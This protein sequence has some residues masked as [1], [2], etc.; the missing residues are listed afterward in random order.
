MIN[1]SESSYDD[2]SVDASGLNGSPSAKDWTDKVGDIEKISGLDFFVGENGTDNNQ[3]CT[4]KNV[5]ALGN[6]RGACPGAPRLSGSY[7]LTGLAHWAHTHD[8]RPLKGDQKVTT[9]AVALL[10]GVPELV[11][12]VPGSSTRTVSILPA[13]R[14]LKPDPDGNCAIV[15]FKIIAQD[16]AA[17]TGT[18][19]VNWE[20]SEQGGDYDQDMKGTLD[21]AIT[22]NTITVTTKVDAKSTDHSM[23]FGYVISGTTQDGFHA[24]SGVNKFSFTDTTGVPG[25]TEC[26][27]TSYSQGDVTE[28]A[29]SHTYSLGTSTAG[30]LEQPLWYAAKYGSF[31]DVNGNDEPDGADGAEWDEDKNGQPDGFFLAS[32][33]SK[34]GS[35]LERFLDVITATTSSSSVATNSVTLNTDTRIFQGR[36]DSGDWSGDVVAFPVGEDGKI[37]QPIWHGRDTVNAQAAAGNR[38]IVTTNEASKDGVPFRWGD[39]TSNN[40]DGIADEQKNALR[41]LCPTCALDDVSV[42]MD[43]LDYLRGSGVDEIKS[44]GGTMRDRTYKLGDIADS[45]PVYVGAPSSFYPDGIEAVSYFD[46]EVAQAE[47]PH[48]LYVGANDGMLHGF[49]ADTGEELF[50]Y[51]PRAVYPNL[52]S[53]T[54]LNYQT[55]HRYFVDSGPTVADVYLGSEKG[56]RT[57]LAGGLGAGGSG[58]FAIDIT[59]PVALKA[60]ETS[61]NERVLWDIRGADTGV[62]ADSGFEDLGLTFSKPALVRLPDYS[63]EGAWAAVFGNGYHDD[64]SQ[65]KAVLYIVDA[66]T[67]HLLSSV[68][69]DSGPGNG[70][71]SVA[72]VDT[73][74]D[75]KVN[76][77]YAGDLEGNLWRFE[78]NGSSGWKVSFGG[79]PLFKNG[80]ADVVTSETTTT[81]QEVCEC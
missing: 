44:A 62:A 16:I 22:A 9:R 21:Y 47:R 79:T 78:P 69:A 10:S 2:N 35:S 61:A 4:A 54:K 43:R 45:E 71:S 75:S 72:P 13:C 77:I 60:D 68:T 52:V 20:D 53:L 28:A 73:D 81:P 1:A 8:I 33:P 66:A 63:H 58:I 18:A 64:T 25:C 51:V 29:T 12:E 3:L 7:L 19:Y 26:D 27:K 36:Y 39:D 31:N 38:R 80:T 48:A 65:G 67:G 5:S 30:L 17:G 59:D 23:G 57:I 74:G 46:F 6:V 34:L 49:D 15:D 32:D 56:W 42:G 24:H 11:I 41:R 14:N 37:A 76:Y 40:G 70:L 55:T 50:A